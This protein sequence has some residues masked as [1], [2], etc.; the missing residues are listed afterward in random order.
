MEKLFL[1][2][3]L[4]KAPKFIQHFYSVILI[5][6]GWVLFA[7]EDLGQGLVFLQKMFGFGAGPGFI[8][9]RA[10]YYILNYGLMLVICVISS[11]PFL[12]NS[13]QKLREKREKLS[14]IMIPVFSVICIFICVAYL[15]DG[16]YNPFIYFRF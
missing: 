7:H 4:E 15:V 10:L 2:K 13:W 14:E 1:L 9:S 12:A 5:I 16:T 8:D 6:I 11:T 3:L